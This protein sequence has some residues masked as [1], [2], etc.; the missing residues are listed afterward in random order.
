M[1]NQKGFSL[2]EMLVVVVIVGIIASIAI[3]QL[4]AARRRANG[5][6]AVSSLRV[7]VSAE[8]AYQ[9]SS[10]AGSYGTL[11][12]LRADGSID[13]VLDSGAKS[14]FVFNIVPTAATAT[15]PAVYDAYANAGVFGS[16]ATATGNKNFYTNESGLIYENEAG[17][18]N[19]PDATSSTDRTVINGT[20]IEE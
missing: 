5:A 15:S 6:S 18:N 2:V 1:K 17:Q 7:I 9:N 3:P 19:P 16:G 8:Q 4:L 12:Q 20:P 13:D 11:N 10:G 14:G